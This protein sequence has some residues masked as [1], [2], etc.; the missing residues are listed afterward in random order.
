MQ[1]CIYAQIHHMR[2]CSE[3]LEVSSERP[4]FGRNSETFGGGG[5]GEE[6]VCMCGG[7][8]GG[9]AAGWTQTLTHS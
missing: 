9:G 5:M 2:N 6:E 8:S 7:A 4:A 1:T 3:A